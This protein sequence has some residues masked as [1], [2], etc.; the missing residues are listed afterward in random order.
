MGLKQLRTRPSISIPNLLFPNKQNVRWHQVSLKWDFS[1]PALTASHLPSLL[2]RTCGRDQLRWSLKGQRL[3]YSLPRWKVC[4]Y[5]WRPL[6]FTK[7]WFLT[8]KI[9]FVSATTTTRWGE[10]AVCFGRQE[11]RNCCRVLEWYPCYRNSPQ[12]VFVFSWPSWGQDFQSLYFYWKMRG[13][14]Y[15]VASR[16][17]ISCTSIWSS[18]VSAP[19]SSP[20]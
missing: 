1:F 8:W 12:L 9:Q 14:S 16:K 2:W 18:L 20:D 19:A 11:T 13:I 10:V 4:T 6:C 3:H 15:S 5:T 7:R 17:S